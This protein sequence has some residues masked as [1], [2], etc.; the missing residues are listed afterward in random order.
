MY[1]ALAALPSVD[2]VMMTRERGLRLLHADVDG[3]RHVVAVLYPVAE[4]VVPVDDGRIARPLRARTND[5]A[6]DVANAFGMT[7]IHGVYNPGRPGGRPMAARNR[8][9]PDQVSLVRERDLTA[10]TMGVDVAH[11]RRLMA[12]ATGVALPTGIALLTGAPLNIESLT[13][14]LVD[15]ETR[16]YERLYGSEDLPY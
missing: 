3:R 11:A 15:A 9:L 7:L 14:P 13:F 1:I 2:Q 16:E 4:V 6:C 5:T 12:E 8:R 10:A